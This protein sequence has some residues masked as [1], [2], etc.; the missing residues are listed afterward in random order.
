MTM[1]FKTKTRLLAVNV[2]S[3]YG[4]AATVGAS[5]VV[6]AYDIKFS[7]NVEEW[8][9]DPHRPSLSEMAPVAGRRHASITFKTALMGSGT[10]DTA[11]QGWGSLIQAAGWAETVDAGVSVSYDPATTALKSVTVK[12]WLD[13][14]SVRLRGCRVQTCAIELLSG[15]PVMMNWTLVGLWDPETDADAV[16]DEANVVPDALTAIIPKA[17]RAALLTVD[18]YA[19]IVERMSLSINNTLAIVPEANTAGSIVRV[20]ITGRSVSGEMDIEAPTKATKNFWDMLVLKS[21]VALEV[22]VG[23]RESGSGTGTLTTMTD[24][25]KNWPADRWNS[26][27]M[28]DSADAVFSIT[29][30]TATALTLSAGTPD[31]GSYIIYDPGELIKITGPKL[32]PTGL[33]DND[34]SGLM[35]HGFPFKLYQNAGDDELV[36]LQT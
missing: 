2:E 24:S 21:R 34:K 35:Y 6:F 27:K 32:V 26:A 13:G 3:T 25:T 28:V 7:P 19:A 10:V 16:K 31:T 20:D 8:A 29:D 11:P 33:P 12:A 30:T 15:Q 36:F 5:Q 1:A 14:I 18:T 9:R 4:T 22:F 23:S 17:F